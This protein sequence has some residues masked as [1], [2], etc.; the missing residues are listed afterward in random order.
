MPGVSLKIHIKNAENLPVSD[1]RGMADP[2][3]TCTIPPKETPEFRTRV[4]EQCLDP[5]WEEDHEIQ[6]YR[7]GDGLLFKVIDQDTAIKRALVGDDFCG[8]VLLEAQEFYPHGFEGEARLENVPNGNPAILRLS[9]CVDDGQVMLPIPP[10]LPPSKTIPHESVHRRPGA[11][12]EDSM[13]SHKHKHKHGSIKPQGAARRIH[14][15]L[16]SAS[17][18]EQVTSGSCDLYCV[19]EVQG[20]LQSKFRTAVVS[21]SVDPFWGKTVDF[22]YNSGEPLVFSVYHKEVWPK[23]DTLLGRALLSGD[24]IT[25]DGF[26]GELRLE[27]DSDGGRRPRS[28]PCLRVQVDVGASSERPA[29]ASAASA[30]RGRQQAAGIEE[31]RPITISELMSKPLQVG[32]SE[33][34]HDSG[35]QKIIVCIQSF[36]GLHGNPATRH[37]MS[38]SC[39]IAGHGVSLRTGYAAE[40]GYQIVW[41]YEGELR[42]F[43]PQDDLE[44]YVSSQGGE[45]HGGAVLHNEQF[46]PFGYSSDITIS[47]PGCG[48]I[49]L[50]RL[51]L[52]IPKEEPPR[53]LGTLGRTVGLTASRLGSLPNH[54]ASSD[55]YRLHRHEVP[56]AIDHGSGRHRLS[57]EGSVVKAGPAHCLSSD[58]SIVKSS[59]G[60][61]LSSEIAGRTGTGCLQAPMPMNGAIA[62]PVGTEKAHSWVVPA[63]TI[64]VPASASTSGPA[65]AHADASSSLV[66]PAVVHRGG[67][68]AGTGVD[69]ASYARPASRMPQRPTVAIGG[70]CV[71]PATSCGYTT[72]VPSS[73]AASYWQPSTATL[74]YS[75]QPSTAGLSY[76]PPAATGLNY[77]MHGV[78]AGAPGIM[79]SACASQNPAARL[80]AEARTGLGSYATHNPAASLL[81]EAR[82]GLSQ[83]LLSLPGVLPPGFPS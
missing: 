43:S 2:Y 35:P 72:T 6:D 12:A 10:K 64:A 77:T 34:R 49:G 59:P 73:T 46:Y 60:H 36:R 23:R 32:K 75:S 68:V 53:A 5:V 57:A 8:D 79:H 15:T 82:S 21:D 67:P 76:S 11:E 38:C 31:E 61:R 13:G 25:P 45:L 14:V 4:V 66:R 40:S 52:V 63:N 27:S 19:C 41:N 17:G 47:R 16:A 74:S 62:P 42:D 70:P 26:D 81:A 44:F 28:G 48:I 69:H 71:M 9:I 55:V 56:P 51:K 54:S 33:V 65:Y 29:A 58:R 83:G 24:R 30:K 39:G 50:L 37:Q 22:D 18:L 1:T 20:N 3:V 78:P 7:P 80:L